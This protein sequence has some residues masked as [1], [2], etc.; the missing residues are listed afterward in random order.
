[1]TGYYYLASSLPFLRFKEKPSVRYRAFLEESS[2]WLSNGDMEQLRL[3]RIDIE[4][5]EYER[6]KNKTLLSWII[7]EN[8]LR[9]E[10][11]KIRA[12]NL[13]IQHE[14]F[15]KP[16]L[17]IDPGLFQKAREAL[18]D[19]SPYKAELALLE[20]RWN[21]LENSEVGHY[22]DITFL[23]IYAL[24]LQLLERM[25][26]FEVERGQKVFHIIYEGNK[27]EEERKRR[28]NNRH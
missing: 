15:L 20:A 8:S 25:E 11:V 10:I 27:D 22:F 4:H 16:H 1:M 6:V 21:F 12:S 17:D 3:S 24:K 7:F 5:I 9:S 19:Q 14:G 18:K 28:E 26:L 23:I 2:M 13:G